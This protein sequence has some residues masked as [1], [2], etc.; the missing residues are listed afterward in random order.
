MS[1]AVAGLVR[2][3]PAGGL[4]HRL[5]VEQGQAGAGMWA[6][7]FFL[8][9]LTSNL[10]SCFNFSHLPSPGGHDPARP[11]LPHRAHPR[12]VGAPPLPPARQGL[13]PAVALPAVPALRAGPPSCATHLRGFPGALLPQGWL[14]GEGP[15]RHLHI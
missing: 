4:H 8:L 9:T 13:H 7:R 15:L 14:Q 5:W 11:R 6:K 2:G 10:R 3:R 1:R 12:A